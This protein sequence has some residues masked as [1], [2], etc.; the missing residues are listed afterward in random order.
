MCSFRVVIGGPANS[1]KSTLAVSLLTAIE[2]LGIETGLHEIDVYSDTHEC[3]LGSKTWAERKKRVS[4][5][6]GEELDCIKK[7]L[8]SFQEDRRRIVLGDLPGNLQ[9]PYIRSMARP[10]HAAIVLSKD[11]DG[12]REWEYFFSDIGIP[13][14]IRAL[15]YLDHQAPIT[16][17]NSDLFFLKLLGRKPLSLNTEVL[18]IAK[19]LLHRESVTVPA[20]EIA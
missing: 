15:S 2:N 6:P 7:V 12:L 17:N 18:R 16:P 19:D 13:V 3:I 5:G 20:L 8:K 4:F 10:A 11:R 9:N 14:I 1:G